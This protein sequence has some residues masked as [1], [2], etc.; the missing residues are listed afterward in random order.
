LLSPSFIILPPL[1]AFAGYWEVRCRRIPNWL[2]LSALLIGLLA[3]PCVD[4]WNGL[5]SALLGV[6][7]GGG[8]FLPFCLLGVLGGGDFKLM[9]AVGA[10]VG[11]PLVLAVLYYTCLAGGAMALIYMILSGRFFST[12]A[13]VGRVLLGR[14]R[15]PQG[16]LQKVPTLPYGIAIA[17]GTLWAILAKL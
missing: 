6:L 8:V 7:V 15:R 9:A 12:L 16:G 5:R 3:A 2:T 1:F 11:F 14:K 17:A 4:G 13:G 10:L